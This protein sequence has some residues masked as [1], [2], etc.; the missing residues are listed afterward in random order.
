MNIMENNTII[1]VDNQIEY[2]YALIERD[3]CLYYSDNESWTEDTRNTLAMSIQDDGD[4]LI[5]DDKYKKLDYLQAVQL[6]ILLRIICS[7]QV[8]EA[9]EKYKI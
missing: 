5:L 1:L 9:A 3:H 2:R 6:S 8:F 4:G 7:D